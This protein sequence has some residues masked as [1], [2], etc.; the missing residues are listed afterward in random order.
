[1]IKSKDPKTGKEISKM[2]EESVGTMLFEYKSENEEYAKGGAEKELD[3]AV[4]RKKKTPTP[5]EEVQAGKDREMAKSGLADPIQTKSEGG[6]KPVVADNTA[7]KEVNLP[8]NPNAGA[9]PFSS[10][11]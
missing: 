8:T 11:P 3:A 4:I 5:A 9:A 2:E 6:A 7:G 1:L 10:I